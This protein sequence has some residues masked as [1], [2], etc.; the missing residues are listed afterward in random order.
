MT[1]A[2][3]LVLIA[4]D[5]IAIA[6]L[7]RRYLDRAGFGVHVEQDGVAA[8][9]AIRR[10][11]P[12]LVVLDIGLPGMDGFA[13][14]AAL[15]EV[16][17]PVPIVFV[18]AHDDEVERVRGLELGAHDYITKPF[19]PRELV[20]RVSGI[21]RRASAG[22]SPSRRH[23][24]LEL[25]ATRRRVTVD[26]VAADL[27]A[28]EFDLL[29]ALVRQPGR[30]FTRPELL[31]QVWGKAD[32]SGGRTVDVHVAQLRAKLGPPAGIRTVHGVG[33]TADEHPG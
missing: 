33:Y 23:G 29:L 1:D 30:V 27:T 19:S 32:Y 9:E 16:G 24:R 15:Q 8:L 12:A 28:T 18:T 13:I 11:R 21:L 20:A 14:C 2:R 10:L 17:D 22:T 5:E 31:A 6:Q 7:E 25:D 4:E 26:G 3:G